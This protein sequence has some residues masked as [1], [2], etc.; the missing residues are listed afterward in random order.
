M[1]T[2]ASAAPPAPICQPLP[3]PFQ[4]LPATPCAWQSRCPQLAAPVRPATPA[5]PA[6]HRHTQLT[7]AARC[8]ARAAP[9]CGAPPTA[10]T[11][12]PPLSCH[13]LGRPKRPPPHATRPACQRR[14]RPK[15][16][17]P[18][19]AQR[20]AR[21]LRPKGKI[22]RLR[23]A[24]KGWRCK[25]HS[26]SLPWPCGRAHCVRNSQT[27]E[28]KSQ[29]NRMRA[30]AACAQARSGAPN[31]PSNHPPSRVAGMAGRA[32]ASAAHAAAPAFRQPAFRPR[33][34]C[35]VWADICADISA[36]PPVRACAG[37]PQ[38]RPP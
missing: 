12:C 37:L 11:G 28:R 26:S 16:P 33:P 9:A 13:L 36:P 25:K 23:T 14:P 38:N 32:T 24:S 8:P 22:G 7:L 6:R 17:V 1:K 34:A 27:G 35:P 20:P 3:P 30:G 18:P 5:A 31:R 10:C 15:Q 2:C 4:P 29:A 21:P 19:S